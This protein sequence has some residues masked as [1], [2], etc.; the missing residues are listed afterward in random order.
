MIGVKE[1]QTEKNILVFLKN[2][3]YLFQ[4]MKYHL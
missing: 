3:I 4:S 2:Y 1:S